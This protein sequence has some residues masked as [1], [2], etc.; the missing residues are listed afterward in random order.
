MLRQGRRLLSLGS[1]G[2]TAKGAI[3]AQLAERLVS[4]ALASSSGTSASVQ[5][6]IGSYPRAFQSLAK[7]FS[8]IAKRSGAAPEQS[9]LHLQKVGGRLPTASTAHNGDVFLMSTSSDSRSSSA[10]E[11]LPI[12]SR[13]KAV[14]V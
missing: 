10:G 12:H 14:L 8:S 3:D 11:R 9:Y 2:A 6:S 1:S 4:G 13:E 7:A 5:A